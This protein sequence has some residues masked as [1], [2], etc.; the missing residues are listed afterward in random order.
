M[1]RVGVV[2]AGPMGRLHVDNVQRLAERGSGFEVGCVCDR[3]P[4]RAQALAARVG[5]RTA[6][7]LHSL[8]DEVDVVIIATP[9]E[10]HFE[11]AATV[12]DR[13]LDVLVEKPMAGRT[14]EGQALVEKA[15]AKG[16]ILQVGQLEWF[17]PSW[18]GA[19]ESVP[20]IERIEVE[21]VQPTSRR[22][23]D[24][25]VIQDLM[26]HDLDWTSRLLASPIVSVEASGRRVE[27]A[28]LDEARARLSFESGSEVEL[29]ASRIHTERR[30]EARFQGGGETV[31]V[32]LDT[33]PGNS[34]E[35]ALSAQWFEFLESVRTRRPSVNSG[36]VGVA[37]LTLVDRVRRAIEED[38]GGE[39]RV[40]DSD[41]RR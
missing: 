34:Q 41:L 25:D 6:E 33:P 14:S 40:D 39:S 31:S 16:R 8:C 30:R 23:R 29:F 21:R 35:D 13:G 20:R 38:S 22:G 27:G 19:A 5:S 17:N 12:L 32:S 24:I 28:R 37:A 4:G 1:K 10:S 9:T 36:E 15:R 26:L 2:G 18:R 11:L 3:H 7:T